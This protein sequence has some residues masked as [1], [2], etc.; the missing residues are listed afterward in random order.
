MIAYQLLAKLRLLTLAGCEGG[1]LLWIGTN[2]SWNL[3]ATE[4]ES[5]LRDWELKQI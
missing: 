3:L 5:I 1:E 4:E 2:E